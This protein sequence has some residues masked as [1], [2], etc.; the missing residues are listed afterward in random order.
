MRHTKLAYLTAA[1]ALLLTAC[2]GG[3]GKSVQIGLKRIAVNLE[4]KAAKKDA[5][6]KLLRPLPVASQAEFATS[7]PKGALRNPVAARPAVA[8][9]RAAE[10][11]RPLEPADVAIKKPPAPG[12]Y[13]YV[14][15]GT[16]KL[17]GGALPSQGPLTGKGTRIV[18][19]IVTT[20]TTNSLGDVAVTYDFD[21]F[22]PGKDGDYT[23]ATY[24]I[25][26]TQLQLVER[27]TKVKDIV[28]T[29]TPTPPIP[30]M[31]FTAEGATWNQGGVDTSDGT[32]MVVQGTIDKREAIDV[33][34]SMFDTYR[35]RSSEHVVNLAAGFISTTDDRGGQCLGQGPSAP[36]A[37]PPQVSPQVEALCATEFQPNTYHVATH[38]GGLFIREDIHTVTQLRAQRLTLDYTTSYLSLTPEP[39]PTAKKT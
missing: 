27:K 36:L 4:F 18:R 23:T 20:K 38:K 39:D 32:A 13:R 1:L 24:R 10:G 29:F 16:Y 37:V 9:P 33:C 2:S 6:E 26:A 15:N 11:A 35:V 5:P 12:L 19:N 14:L 3:D 8:C 7:L 28:D 34:G 21:V 31:V 17:E 30:L 25:T 22:Q